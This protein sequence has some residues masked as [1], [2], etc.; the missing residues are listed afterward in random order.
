MDPIIELLVGALAAAAQATAKTSVTE[1]SRDAYSEIRRYINHRYSTVR[2][3]VLEEEPDSKGQQLVV[4]EKL[5]KAGAEQDPVL[6]ELS[7]VLL[8]TLV[9]N[10]PDVGKAVGVEL[11]NLL[12][13]CYGSV[14]LNDVRSRSGTIIIEDVGSLRKK[15][16]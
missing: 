15:T 10:D 12:A 3:D 9:T 8:K 6:L 7:K 4:Q 13:G 11:K 14:N 2:L 16:D 5:Q 1:A